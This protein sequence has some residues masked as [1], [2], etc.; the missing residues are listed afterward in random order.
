MAEIVIVGGGAAGMMCAAHAAEGGREVLLLE[1]NE[2]LGKKLFITGKGRCN[3]TNEAGPEQMMECIIS[4]PRF[5]NSSL[6]SFSSED[7]V[8]YFSERGLALKT[9]RGGRIFPESDKSSDVIRALEK[10]LEELSVRIRLHTEVTGISPSEEGYLLSVRSPRGKEE[11]LRAKA[12][13]IATGG[14]S[15]PATGSTGDGF[16]F[17]H[18]L[19]LALKDRTPSLV[20]MKVKEIEECRRLMGLSLKNTGIAFRKEGKVLFRD[21]GEM[22]FTH[23]GISGPMILSASA[24]IPG[25][26]YKG[27]LS[28]IIDLKPALSQ[29]KL[30][31]RLLRDFKESENRNFIHALHGLLPGKLLP[32]ILERSQIPPDKKVHSVTRQERERLLRLLKEFP[33]TVTGLR[34]YEEA[35]IT[36]GG[37]SVK[38]IHPKTMESRKYPGLYFVGEVLDVDA[39][40]GGYNLQIAWS[41]A[42]AAGRALAERKPI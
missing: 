38:E 19:G 1:K 26:A 40:T 36:K 42:A 8:R 22:L 20:P 17:A 29:E 10:R 2:K 27:G 9:E 3:L 37:V 7:T 23:F 25:D 39:L 11:N 30:D 28:L 34:G 35:V 31:Q 14:L 33:L 21:F 13:V 12:L 5:M 15:Y 6:R 18:S 4:N 32:V 24:R 16:R 41:T